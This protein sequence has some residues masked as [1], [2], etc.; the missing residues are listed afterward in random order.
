[1]I[2]VQGGQDSASVLTPG[3]HTNIPKSH[4]GRNRSHTGSQ[5]GNH[6]M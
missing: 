2:G 6:G 5:H 4:G 3:T 1:M